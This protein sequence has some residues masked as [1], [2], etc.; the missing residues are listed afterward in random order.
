[1]AQQEAI[2]YTLTKFEYI[3]IHKINIFEFNFNLIIS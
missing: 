2:H 1:M 3:L